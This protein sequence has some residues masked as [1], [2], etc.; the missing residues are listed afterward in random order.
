MRE[1]VIYQRIL[2]E[3]RQEG[4][5]IAFEEEAKRILILL[6]SE[7]LGPLPATVNEVLDGIHDHERI[8]Q[9]IKRINS[10]SSWDELLA[11]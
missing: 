5:Q 2:R 1:S 11:E 10:V 7:H 8:E 4:R 3:G 9:L 6:G